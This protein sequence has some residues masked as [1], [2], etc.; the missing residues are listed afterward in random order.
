[1]KK[2]IVI[3]LVLI[4]VGA[5]GFGTYEYFH[6]SGSKTSGR[7]SSDSEDAV[8][9]ETVS[10]ITGY[11]TGS[12]V[13]PRYSGEA[14]AQATL[15]VSLDSDRTVKECYVKEGDIV[16]EGQKLFAYDTQ[17]DEDKIAQD[18]IDIEKYQM[19]IASN[20]TQ[21]TQ[22]EKLQNSAEDEDDRTEAYLQIL[23]LQN[24]NRSLEYEIEKTQ[25]EI[26]SLQESIADAVVTADMD[27]YVQKIS[28]LND[29]DDYGYSDDS[30]YITILAEGDYRIKGTVNELG[31]DAVYVGMPMIA[32][33]RSDP[34]QS[35]K[36]TVTEISTEKDEDDDE[37]YYYYYYGSS[38]T[39]T[40][41]FYVELDSAG[42][43]LLGQHVY[44][45]KDAGQT[46][47]KSGLWLDDYYIMHE[48][49]EA[50]VWL[51]SLSNEIEKHEIS[52]G[53]FDEELNEYEVTDGLEP[54]DYIAYP[55][56]DIQEGDPVYYSDI[57]S[58]SE[59]DD[60]DDDDWDDDDW[61]DDDWD[62]DDWDD[63]DWDD[64]D[65]DDDWDDDD[66][67]DDDWDDD[68]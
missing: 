1:M 22:Q 19:N 49:E 24:E 27:G 35:W 50:Y 5:G 2:G 28:N 4:L 31:Y 48:G 25:I 16:E 12:G 32:Y 23:S 63:D 55:L 11:G 53:S 14:V 61:D 20:E 37:G 18:E 38:D 40:Y 47:E 9:V 26:D 56:D 10:T 46:E 65:W 45:E 8:Y 6:L 21:I 29:Y 57:A 39:S 43:L 68:D 36:G 60:W 17:E 64:D 67:D 58:V 33:S 66:W 44:L 54:D 13:I 52:L 62:D 42:G 15:E 41:T 51:A 7:V 34:D 3:L 59:D 30:T